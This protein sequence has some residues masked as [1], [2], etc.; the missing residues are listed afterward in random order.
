MKNYGKEHL[1]G[2]AS[3]LGY[4]GSDLEK[5]LILLEKILILLHATKGYSYSRLLIGS[6]TNATKQTEVSFDFYSLPNY[7][8]VPT[9]F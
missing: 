5:V 6:G 2:V 1:Y 4:Q 3:F 7:H 8:L 9:N